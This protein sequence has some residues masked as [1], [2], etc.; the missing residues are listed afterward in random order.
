M[1]YSLFEVIVYGWNC[2]GFTFVGVIDKL[3][4]WGW[5]DVTWGIIKVGACVSVDVHI[6]N[7]Q[8]WPLSF[9]HTTPQR[10]HTHERLCQLFKNRKLEES[11]RSYWD[12]CAIPWKI[13]AAFRAL[14][15]QKKWST[16][17]P[18]TGSRFLPTKADHKVTEKMEMSWLYK[19]SWESQGREAGLALLAP[20][21]TLMNTRLSSS[22][23][24]P[25]D[26][27]VSE[28]T[29][30]GSPEWHASKL[31]GRVN[32]CPSTNSTLMPKFQINIF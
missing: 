2:F 27:F 25:L 11:C 5:T 4:S 3:G 23:W 8:L 24:P 19:Q 32:P 10:W 15:H 7:T 29:P 31:P 18:S 17:L 26:P 16:T 22:F 14:G 6:Q 12:C 30:T 28:E 9:T 21:G 1:F 13:P 20:E